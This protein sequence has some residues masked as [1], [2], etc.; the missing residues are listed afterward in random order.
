MKH[1]LDLF[2]VVAD[3]V[4]PPVLVA[5]GPVWPVTQLVSALKGVD[6]TLFQFDV[7]QADRLREK[8]VQE[9]L[10]AEVVVGADVWDL[11]AKF[12]TVIFPA[13]V[14]ADYELKLD[15]VEQGYHAVV[16]WG[17]VHHPQRVRPRHHLP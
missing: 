7:Y 4:A 1:L 9:K 8:L 11:P 2:P 10:T 17:A 16:P 5:L 13:S 15:V 6:T 12:N 14:Q 3:R